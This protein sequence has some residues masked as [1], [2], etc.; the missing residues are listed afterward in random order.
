MNAN[1]PHH[2]FS[3]A[4]TEALGSS[5]QGEIWQSDHQAEK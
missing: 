1:D 4:E 3:F 5:N 2:G